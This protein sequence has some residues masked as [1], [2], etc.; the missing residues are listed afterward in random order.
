M[1]AESREEVGKEEIGKK[2]ISRAFAAFL[3]H[4]SCNLL[5]NV[6]HVPLWGIGLL[7]LLKIEEFLNAEVPSDFLQFLFGLFEVL[8][9][10]MAV[11][12]MYEHDTH[13]SNDTEGH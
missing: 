13:Q 9:V 6:Q 12:S 8:V 5:H 7:Q 3:R 4:I 11:S 10:K 1:L 2:V